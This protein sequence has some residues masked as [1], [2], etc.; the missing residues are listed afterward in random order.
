M[1]NLRFTRLGGILGVHLDGQVQCG[2]EGL[3]LASFY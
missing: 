1:G 3:E 2:I